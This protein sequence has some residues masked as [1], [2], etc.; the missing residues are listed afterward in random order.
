M[1]DGAKTSQSKSYSAVDFFL[2][3]IKVSNEVCLESNYNSVEIPWLVVLE[4]V[5]KMPNMAVRVVKTR[6]SRV[7]ELREYRKQEKIDNNLLSTVFI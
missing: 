7:E 3:I 5:T 6:H 2:R 4:A 1:C